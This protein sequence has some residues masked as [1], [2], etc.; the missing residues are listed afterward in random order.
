MGDYIGGGIVG[1]IKPD[2]RSVDYSQMAIIPKVLVMRL[3][4]CYTGVTETVALVNTFL[5]T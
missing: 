1:Q 3:I 4:P 2:T 5:L